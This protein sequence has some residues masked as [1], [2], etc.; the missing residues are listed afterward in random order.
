[1]TLLLALLATASAGCNQ[2]PADTTGSRSPAVPTNLELLNVSYDPTRELWKDINAEFIANWTRDHGGSLKIKQS[3]GGSA[4]QARAVID[5]LEADIVTLALWTDTDAVR[6]KGLIAPG[7]EDRLP[8]QSLPYRSTIVFVVRKGNPKAIADWADLV[9]KNVSVITPNPKTSG[10]GKL[11]FL[12]AWGSVLK[13]GGTEDD[14]R[15]FITRLY[16]RVPVLDTGAR[17]ATTTFA[18]KGLGDVHLTWENEAHLEVAESKGDLEI[19]YPKVSILAEPHVAL[20]D[21]NVD[22]KLTRTVAEEYL[23]FLY[24]RRGQELI[25]KHYYRPSD[26]EVLAANRARFPEITLFPVT[27]LVGNW[28]EAQGKFFAEGGVFDVIYQPAPN[29]DRSDL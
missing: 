14:A 19:V 2:S 4:T 18:Q 25:A 17:G 6:K 3:H 23:K 29:V 7:W 20:V 15:E 9:A 11:A 26:P 21:A 28:D 1:M 8:H 22:R 16:Q 13:N 12:A 10:N 27:D 24:T 5:G